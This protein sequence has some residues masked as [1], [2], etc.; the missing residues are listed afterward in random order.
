MTDVTQTFHPFIHSCRLSSW[1][2]AMKNV[3]VNRVKGIGCRRLLVA[4][5]VLVGA[6]GIADGLG[7]RQYT[8]IISG[9]MS[10][11]DWTSSVFLCIIY[12]GLYFGAVLAAPILALAALIEAGMKV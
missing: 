12:I 3:N 6:Y 8:S 1:R 5:A 2:A 9:T 11:G 10:A 4:A 7:L